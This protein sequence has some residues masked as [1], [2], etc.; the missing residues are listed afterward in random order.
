[1]QK[2]QCLIF[3][4]TG[5]GKK[6]GGINTFN[7]EICKALKSILPEYYHIICICPEVDQNTFIE[8]T[9]HN[10]EIYYTKKF[11]K[12]DD[13]VNDILFFLKSKKYNNISWWVGHDVTTGFIAHRCKIESHKGKLAIFHHMSFINYTGFKHKNGKSVIDRSNEQRDIL[14]KSDIILSIGPKL[15]HSAQNLINNKSI[16]IKQITPGLMEIAP[17]Q[18][19]EPFQAIVVGRLGNTDDIIKQ[20]KLSVAAF[21]HALKR[22]NQLFSHDD[23]I[24]L[25]GVP[26]N[27][28]EDTYKELQELAHS[29]AERLVNERWSPLTGQEVAVS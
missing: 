26:E 10:I 7:A 18:A 27:E 19:K 12:H 29:R 24:I 11:D 1:M 9:K 14:S 21:A 3:I 5:W 20:F 28:S 13:V 4:S 22:Y 8:S 16:A 23:R 17:T 25:F 2:K 6:Y 15:F